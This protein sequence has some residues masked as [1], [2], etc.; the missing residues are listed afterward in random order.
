M[1]SGP[2]KHYI[3]DLLQLF[4]YIGYLQF[5]NYCAKPFTSIYLN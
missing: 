4:A 1:V 5:P 3:N 2:Y